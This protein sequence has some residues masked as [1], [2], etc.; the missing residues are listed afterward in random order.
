MNKA[1]IVSHETPPLDDLG[2]IPRV[3]VKEIL[4]KWDKLSVQEKVAIIDYLN[5]H[6]IAMLENES[7]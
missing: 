7:E 6:N 1:K 3:R 4:D 5:D 2:P